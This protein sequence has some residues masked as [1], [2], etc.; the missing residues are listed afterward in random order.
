MP[1]LLAVGQVGGA[2]DGTTAEQLA[3]ARADVRMLADGCALLGDAAAA[4]ALQQLGRVLEEADAAG[5]AKARELT[6]Q[7]ALLL[8][9]WLPGPGE[10]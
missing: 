2:G 7:A 6:D 3:T 8:G 9:R 1:R 10:N 5:T 4:R